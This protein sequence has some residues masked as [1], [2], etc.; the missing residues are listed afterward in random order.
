MSATDLDE[1][2]EEIIFG[3]MPKRFMSD[4][5]LAQP[6][7]VKQA[8]IDAGWVTPENATKVQ[9]MVNQIANLTNDMTQLPIIQYAKPNLMTGQE[10][11]DK[12]KKELWKS[13]E[14]KRI[15]QGD[16]G[17]SHDRFYRVGGLSFMYNRALHAAKK[18]AGLE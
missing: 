11:Y 15:N 6:E 5:M 9:E 18:A 16:D 2:L 10:W 7:Q 12:F 8:F 17:E 3:D 1:K 13:P 14:Q 4:F